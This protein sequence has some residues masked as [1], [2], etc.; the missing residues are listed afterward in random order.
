MNYVGKYRFIP[1][2]HTVEGTKYTYLV[3]E[4][5][6]IFEK[7]ILLGQKE[8][9]DQEKIKLWNGI[10]QVSEYIALGFKY[11]IRTNY[12]KKTPKGKAV[13]A[14]FL[15]MCALFGSDE[16][17]EKIESSLSDLAQNSILYS[18]GMDSYKNNK[19]FIWNKIK[20]NAYT[21]V[22]K[23][24]TEVVFMQL[25]FD[26]LSTEVQA[27]DTIAESPEDFIEIGIQ[28]SLSAE[29][30]IEKAGLNKRMP[31]AIEKA[32]INYLDHG[33]TED[34]RAIQPYLDIIYKRLHLN[35]E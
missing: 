27:I 1:S 6:E 32:I 21:T 34:L 20:P 26:F 8:L 33:E 29:E 2:I 13:T 35:G 9:S 15:R 16:Y 31:S 12:D 19:A 4:Y 25:C 18:L 10:I 3:K 24:A 11:I 30:M 23:H 14:M 17:Y 5:H 22:I 7:T 28:D